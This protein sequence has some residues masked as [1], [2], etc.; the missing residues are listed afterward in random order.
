MLST[1]D[2]LRVGNLM[3]LDPIVIGSDQPAADAER[4]LK[5]YRVGGLPVV[6]G[7]D[8]VG[9][10]SQADLMVARSSEM[11]GANW[12]RM[13]VRHLMTHPA[14]TVHATATLAHAAKLMIQRHIHRLVVVSDGGEP[15]GVLTTLDLLRVLTEDP[16]SS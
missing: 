3:S 4:L 14:I 10:I 13:R 16:A 6:E 11:I 15:I 7:G 2:D 8:L 9:V 12:D 1:S 5:T